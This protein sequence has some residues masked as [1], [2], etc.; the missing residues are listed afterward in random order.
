MSNENYK[1]T[2][3]KKTRKGIRVIFNDGD[4]ALI[5]FERLGLTTYDSIYKIE[6]P[7]PW[8]VNLYNK[9]GILI[10]ELPWDFVIYFSLKKLAEYKT[11][12]ISD[13][14]TKNSELISIINKM[15][16]ILA[17]PLTTRTEATPQLKLIRAI[18][19]AWITGLNL[20]QKLEKEAKKND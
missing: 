12:R 9:D 14:E 6:L 4:E 13:L 1:M 3:A 16:T 18:D 19:E 15:T 20:L 5:P 7:N 10:E 8:Q 2:N 11:E 17:N